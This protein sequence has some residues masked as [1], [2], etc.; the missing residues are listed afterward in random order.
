M[1][2]D[3][4]PKTGKHEVKILLVDDNTANLQVL[5]ETL[6]PLGCKMLIAKSGASALSIIEKTVPDLVLLDIMM[7]EMDGYEVAAA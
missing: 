6:E 2:N 3:E 1:M 5:R 7:P 4:H